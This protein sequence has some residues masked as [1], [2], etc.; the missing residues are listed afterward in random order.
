MNPLVLLAVFVVVSAISWPVMKVGVAHVTP[1]WFSEARLVLATAVLL[2]VAR[3][4]GS[5]LLPERGDW[6]IVLGVGLTQMTLFVGLSHYAL[7]VADAGR[8]AV[9][10]YTTPLWVAPLAYFVLRE[11]LGWRQGVGAILGLAGIVVL[12][13]PAHFAWTDRRAVIAHAAL[14][15]AALGWAVA[16]LLVRAHR[17]RGTA[18]QTAPWQMMV[19]AIVLLPV[20]WLLEGPPPAV[21]SWQGLAALF[22]TAPFAT[23]LAF[24]C[25]VSAGQ[26]LPATTIAV[27]S[28]GTPALGVVLAALALGETLS[29]PV[30]AALGLIVAGV[31]VTVLQRRP[32]PA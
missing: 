5:R 13:D 16:I 12:V 21:W 32:P 10:V 17:W 26:R 20:A 24:W 27:G 15:A 2:A 23:A 25:I 18:L 29:V 11:P 9:L 30:L 19:G 14:L 4:T 7:T 3:L 22:Y 28:L 8:S 1:F 31:L 6:P